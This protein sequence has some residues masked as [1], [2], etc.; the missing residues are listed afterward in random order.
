MAHLP[1]ISDEDAGPEARSLFEHSRQMFGR[2][3]NAMRVAAHSPKLAQ[4]IYGFMVA[5]L[6]EEVTGILDKRTKTLVILKTSTLNGC[7]Y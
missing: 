4:S 6:R 7:K 1:I 2:V 5:A 3:A